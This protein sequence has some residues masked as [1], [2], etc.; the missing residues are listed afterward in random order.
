MCSSH[1]LI[2]SALLR[3]KIS[4]QC[5]YRPLISHSHR[6]DM[7]NR[8]NSSVNSC[9]HTRRQQQTQILV[10]R[11][12]IFISDTRTILR[13]HTKTP[14]RCFFLMLLWEY[15]IIIAFLFRWAPLKLPWYTNPDSLPQ[16]QH[17]QSAL[18][19]RGGASCCFTEARLGPI[20]S[21]QK[22]RAT[23]R[24][25]SLRPGFTDRV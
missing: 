3:S 8:D 20:R 13:L 10:L 5:F 23:L 17:S 11:R 4:N 16:S 6:W 18:R 19:W 24:F 2:R 14:L 21:K 12:N 25:T 22:N 7:I 1:F 9:L 15:T